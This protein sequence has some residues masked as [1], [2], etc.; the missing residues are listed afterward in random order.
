[1]IYRLPIVRKVSCCWLLL[2]AAAG[3]NA[4]ETAD[5]ALRHSCLQA[6]QQAS[7]P[8]A[9]LCRAYIEGFLDGALLTDAAIIQS[10]MDEPDARSTFFERAYR[11]R[12]G[13]T[14]KPL[15]PTYLAKFCLPDSMDSAEIVATLVQHFDEE[16]LKTQPLKHVLYQ[17]LKDVYS[18]SDHS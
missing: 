15:P 8:Q 1:M 10:I 18:C 6:K 11:T 5:Q 4:T 12:V 7:H 13:T 2:V 3:A 17:T 14:R 9:G 16:M